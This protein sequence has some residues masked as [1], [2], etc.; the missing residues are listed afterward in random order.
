M[1]TFTLQTGRTG[2]TVGLA[3][4]SPSY[5]DNCPLLGDHER[6]NSNGRVDCF[7][8]TIGGDYRTCVVYNKDSNFQVHEIGVGGENI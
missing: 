5:I 8:R 1:E 7:T 6:C 4:D 3:S 2:L